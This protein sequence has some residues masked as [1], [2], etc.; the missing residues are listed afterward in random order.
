M[1]LDKCIFCQIAKGETP[2][3]IVYKDDEI[4]AFEDVNP[5]APV[6]IL[7]AP[8]RHIPSIRE[9]SGKDKDVIGKI[10]LV[11]K[12][13]ARDKNIEDGFRIVVN[14]GVGAGQSVGHLHFHLLGG[15]RFRWP[16]G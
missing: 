13:I 16:P 9:L 15:R 14:S 12:E 7:L 3:R 10:Y 1:D 5:Q 4:V 11:A 8:R 6:H 2:A